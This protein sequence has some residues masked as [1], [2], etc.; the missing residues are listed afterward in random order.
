[1][2]TMNFAQGRPLDLVALGRIAVDINPTQYHQ[3]LYEC[4]TFMRYVGGSPANVSV[5][6]ARLGA[7]VGFIGKVSGDGLGEYA[8][9]YFAK[10]GI[11]VS[12]IRRCEDKSRMGLAFTEVLGDGSSSILMYRDRAADLQLEPAE[13]SLQ[14]LQS[15]KIL[16]VSGTALAQSPSREAALK[17]T[18]LAKEAGCFIVFDIDYRA[19]SWR[20]DEEISVYYSLLA[21]QA[22][23]ILGSR[24]E[25]NLMEQKILGEHCSDAKS[26]EYWLGQQAKIVIIKHG[27]DGSMVFTKEGDAYRV[28][29]MPIKLLKSFGG[30]DAYAASLLYGLLNGWALEESLTYASVAAAK[31]VASKACSEDMPRLAELTAFVQESRAAHGELVEKLVESEGV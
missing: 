29:P 22:D 16:L 6:L 5:G 7:K 11:D 1:M 14:Y 9:R 18:L 17:A 4:D 8:V 31:L 30:G 2:H 20:N 12:N 28:R 15:A 23:I 13:V 24:E 3:P 21:K 26:A 25:Y 19:Y 10:E 27:K